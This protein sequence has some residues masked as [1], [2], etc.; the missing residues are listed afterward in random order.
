MKLLV[1]GGTGFIGGNFIN[2]VPEEIEVFAITR[3]KNKSKVKLNRNVNWIYKD[4]HSVNSK[5]LEGIDA[6]IHFAS[7]GVSPQKAT[8]EEYYHF[9]VNCTL[10]LLRAAAESGVKRI[11][12]SGSY[13]EYGL[14]AN[15]HEYISAST[16][17]LPTT[18]YASSKAAAFEL[19]YA[20]CID[21][22]ISLFYNRIFSAYGEGQFEGN[23]WPSL[24]KAALNHEDFP[25]T[26]GELIRDFISVEDVAFEFLQD[27]KSHMN[28]KFVPNVRNICSGKGIS[29][30]DF[31]STWWNIW[32]AK[33]KLLP[34]TIPSRKDELQRFVGEPK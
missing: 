19:A 15:S 17:L 18:A 32:N 21:A 30:L 23:L 2:L 31:A 7:V 22:K 3:N 10:S 16:A 25:M 28:D 12:M 27:I 24:R 20:F 29:I 1:T 26:N 6:V 11:I 14:S 4:L 13:M 34:G 8:W 9:N 33:G 5:D